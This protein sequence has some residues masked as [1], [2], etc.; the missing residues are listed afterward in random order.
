MLRSNIPLT[1]GI[2]P[3]GVIP[4]YKRFS[5]NIPPQIICALMITFPGYCNMIGPSTQTFDPRRDADGTMAWRYYF[6]ILKKIFYR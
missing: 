1:P 4:V 5:E 3:C 6:M 2:T